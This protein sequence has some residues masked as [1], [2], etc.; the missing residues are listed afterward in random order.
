MAEVLTILNNGAPFSVRKVLSE[1]KVGKDGKV[2]KAKFGDV[3]EIK[4]GAIQLDKLTANMVLSVYKERCSLV[5]VTV[6]KDA[7]N[8]EIKKLSAEKEK[9]HAELEKVKQELEDATKACQSANEE[10]AKVKEEL[11]K[12]TQ[13]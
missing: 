12:A 11:A 4:T 2:E 6:S 10:L 5:D 8:A 1:K 13:K 7:E 9:L 3:I